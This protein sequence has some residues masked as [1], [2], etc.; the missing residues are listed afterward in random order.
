MT[1]GS[2]R[3]DGTVMRVPTSTG[4]IEDGR[5]LD[6]QLLVL[7]R[8]LIENLWT[9][10][11]LLVAFGVPISLSRLVYTDWLPVYTMHLALGIIAFLIAGL[12]KQL[13]FPW[14]ANSFLL[15]L[16][17]VGIPGIFTF[18]LAASSVWWLVLSCFVASTVYSVRVGAL[19]AA[20]TG[21]VL[22]LAGAG[23]ISG[24]LSL[25]LNLNQYHS[26]LTAWMTLVV[27]TGSFAILL[28]R[29]SGSHQRSLYH[30]L[31]LIRR[32]R[33][34][35]NDLYDKAPCGYHSLDA[36]GRFLR[37]NQTELRWL[38]LQSNEIVGRS[39]LDFVTP[40]S[41]ERFNANFP[42]FKERGFVNDLEFEIVRRDGS[43]LPVLL[44]ATAVK[45]ASGAFLMSRSTLFDISER[46]RLE[47]AL[48]LQARTDSLTGLA[49]RRDFYERADREIA[50]ARRQLTPLGLLMLDVDHFKQI[51]DHYGHAA[52]DAVLKVLSA[53]LG[54]EIRVID[55]AARLGGEEFAVLLPAT[56]SGWALQAAERIRA[57]LASEVVAVDGQS[58]RF[59][60]SIGASMVKEDDRTIE[61]ALRRADEA[62]YLA[63]KQGRNQVCLYSPEQ[64]L[65][66]EPKT[67]ETGLIF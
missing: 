67:T 60:V 14:L 34:E 46:K 8:E 42:A 7:R 54:M 44:S 18:G 51:N 16:W 38:G 39:F 56:D 48:R 25:P 45:D 29:A 61:E 22:G 47:D 33:D 20:G 5:E 43:K 26:E 58:I 59:T 36:K 63:K 66:S 52:G 21:A 50:L 2:L 57:R 10:M 24:A 53:S 30:M 64:R 1:D 37:I 49:N 15:F 12:R 11:R 55:I 4:D 35:V 9:G 62:L 19:L 6:A 32:Q 41:R 40:E 3:L 23:F 17:A 31:N 13:S 65:K 28:L 27:V